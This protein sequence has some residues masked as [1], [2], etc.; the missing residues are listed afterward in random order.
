MNMSPL[1]A[2]DL[3]VYAEQLERRI[4]AAIVELSKRPDS[5]DE[6]VWLE[7]AQRHLAQ[8]R[9][10]NGDLL[11]RA[12]RIP[13]LEPARNEAGRTLQSAVVDAVEQ[14]Y[15][16]LHRADSGRS[17]V[18]DVLYANLKL[19]HLRRAGREPLQSFCTEFERRLGSSYV[20]RMLAEER[21][22]PVVPALAELRRSFDAWRAIFASPSLTEAETR[23]LQD[24]LATAA[25][26]MELRCRQAVLLAEAALVSAKDLRETSGIFNKPRKRPA[27]PVGGSANVTLVPDGRDGT[28]SLS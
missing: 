11:T 9:K 5:K 6:T 19:A 16:A 12:L 8:A 24:G 13:E 3:L 22:L 26:R 28:N 7:A 14:L 2:F 17:P 27:H 18:C 23:S 21:Y 1:D 20:T 15:A 4:G 25:H 10:A